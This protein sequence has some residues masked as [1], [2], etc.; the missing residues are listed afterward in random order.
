MYSWPASGDWKEK[1]TGTERPFFACYKLLVAICLILL[2]PPPPSPIA[3]SK[4]FKTHT[5]QKLQ[6]ASLGLFKLFVLA[7][8][9]EY[10]MS[11]PYA[12]SLVF[13]L[14]EDPLLHRRS[15][16]SQEKSSRSWG[17]DFWSDIIW[18]IY[19]KYDASKAGVEFFVLI[20]VFAVHFARHI[21][22]R[23]YISS[24]VVL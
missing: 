6:G 4:Q 3:S 8:L 16:K 2:P 18:T 20:Y 15:F 5:Q 19:L 10:C 11:F 14:S 24:I 17:L 12:F 23:W 22:W 9:F 13:W 1:V 7:I 21:V